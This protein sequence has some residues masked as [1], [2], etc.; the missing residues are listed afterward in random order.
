MVGECFDLRLYIFKKILCH[1]ENCKNLI[2]L[3]ANKIYE[4]FYN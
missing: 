3:Y 4:K 1:F 2:F